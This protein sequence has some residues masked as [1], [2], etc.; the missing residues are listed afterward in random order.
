MG[1][2]GDLYR[3]ENSRVDVVTSCDGEPVPDRGAADAILAEGPIAKGERIAVAEG[4]DG[5]VLAVGE[6]DLCWPPPVGATKPAMA[7]WSVRELDIRDYQDASL[8][9]GSG[10]T[11]ARR[12][13][14]AGKAAARRGLLT[15]RCEVLGG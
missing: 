14:Y 6:D 5:E 12:W 3:F 11:V 9:R 1:I 8:I 15:A 10:R 2:Q 13:R 4:S 7:M